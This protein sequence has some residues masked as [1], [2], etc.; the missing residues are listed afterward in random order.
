MSVALKELDVNHRNLW[1]V[2]L[3]PLKYAKIPKQGSA[4]RL[5]PDSGATAEISAAQQCPPHPHR[6]SDVKDLM[7]FEEMLLVQCALLPFSSP[8]SHS[9]KPPV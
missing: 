8:R 3:L 7:P 5:S 9:S 1:E 6:L 2:G 4:F